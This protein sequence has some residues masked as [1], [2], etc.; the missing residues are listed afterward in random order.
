MIID[1]TDGGVMRKVKLA[2]PDDLP[3]KMRRRGRVVCVCEIKI[4]IKSATGAQREL[5]KVQTLF[6]I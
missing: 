6:F 1:Q 2:A 4:K 3:E 5:F